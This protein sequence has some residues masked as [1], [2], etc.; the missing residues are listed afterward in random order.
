MAGV[1]P[2]KKRKTDKNLTSALH[3]KSAQP[4]K[5]IQIWNELHSKAIKNT[6]RGGKG[7]GLRSGL[8]SWNRKGRW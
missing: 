5:N 2:L 8:H 7:H 1:V 6:G 3:D 4:E